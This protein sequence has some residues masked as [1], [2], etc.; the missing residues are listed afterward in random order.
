MNQG[1]S[2][3]E[4][5]VDVLIDRM[6]LPHTTTSFDHDSF[7]HF[8]MSPDQPTNMNGSDRYHDYLSPVAHA[9]KLL[10]NYKV[11]AGSLHLNRE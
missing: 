1:N 7:S 8:N 10:N 9:Q 3:N 11:S 6:H 4:S 5:I 2:L